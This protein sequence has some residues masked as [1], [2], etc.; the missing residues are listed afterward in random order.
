MLI[1][2]IM[3]ISGNGGFSYFGVDDITASYGSYVSLP[4]NLF[5]RTGY[6][7]FS[8]NRNPNASSIEI[9]NYEAAYNLTDNQDAVVT[10][11]AICQPNN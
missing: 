1:G 9:E 3:I 10:L 4:C 5:N 6:T 8:W 2:L 11:Y 7:F